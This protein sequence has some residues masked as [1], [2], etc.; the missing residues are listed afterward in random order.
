MLDISVDSLKEM[1]VFADMP[2]EN[3]SLL[4]SNDPVCIPNL[5]WQRIFWDTITFLTFE[6]T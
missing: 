4:K 5:N 2:N 3:F 1:K 6:K